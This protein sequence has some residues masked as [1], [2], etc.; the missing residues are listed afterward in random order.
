MTSAAQYDQQL[1]QSGEVVISQDRRRI[2]VALIGA[3]VFVAVGVW[4]ISSGSN[5]I[6]W[7]AVGFFGILGVPVLLVQMAR[8]RKVTVTPSHVEIGGLPALP[9]SETTSVGLIEVHGTPIGMIELTP[10]GRGLVAQHS[11]AGERAL[12]RMN[13]HVAGRP[14]VALPAG[15]D[16]DLPDLLHWLTT[17]RERSLSR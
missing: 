2:L 1:H 3:L 16:A 11:N 14:S 13:D 8:V 5:L 12:H 9:W 6:G 7:A 10:R 4:L 15:L 17:V